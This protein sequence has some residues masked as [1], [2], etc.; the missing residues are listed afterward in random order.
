[1]HTEF[2]N[3][4][5][6]IHQLHKTAENQHPYFLRQLRSSSAPPAGCCV[7]RGAGARPKTLSLGYKDVFTTSTFLNQRLRTN[8]NNEFIEKI[9]VKNIKE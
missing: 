8:G 2:R 9:T 3:K 5:K 1:M 6:N 4:L 7:R